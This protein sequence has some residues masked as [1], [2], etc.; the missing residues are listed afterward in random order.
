ML[1][2]DPVDLGY[3][4]FRRAHAVDELPVIAEQQHARRIL[5][6]PAH[7]LQPLDGTLAGPLAQWRRQQG[8]DAGIGR[9]LLRALGARGLV[10]HDVALGVVFPVHSLHTKTQAFG[11]DVSS[12]VRALFR[13]G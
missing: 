4:L 6:Q 13:R 3:M 9:W 1:G 2:R 12:R 10:Q 5:V 8:I 7:G 11:I